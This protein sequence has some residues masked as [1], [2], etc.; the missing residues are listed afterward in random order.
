MRTPFITFLAFLHLFQNLIF[1]K[2]NLRIV[3]FSASS[4]TQGQRANYILKY[5]FDFYDFYY[6]LNH[7]ILIEFGDEHSANY[8]TDVTCV[9]GIDGHMDGVSLATRIKDNRLFIR[10]PHYFGY[11]HYS[12]VR[13]YMNNLG[14]TDK[15]KLT[16]VISDLLNPSV[17]FASSYW[18]RFYN[19]CNNK[20]VHTNHSKISYEPDSHNIELMAKST[21]AFVPDGHYS[22]PVILTINQKLTRNIKIRAYSVQSGVEIIPNVFDFEAG[23]INLKKFRI[24]PQKKFLEMNK[25][26]SLLIKFELLSESKKPVRFPELALEVLNFDNA[27]QVE[28]FR[29]Q[30]KICFPV[31]EVY[32]SINHFSQGKLTFPINIRLSHPF[33]YNLTINDF[34]S[35]WLGDENIK[36][37]PKNLTIHKGEKEFGLRV[38]IQTYKYVEF[39]LDHNMRLYDSNTFRA[40]NMKN[41][42]EKQLKTTIQDSLVN[43]MKTTKNEIIDFDSWKDILTEIPLDEEFFLRYTLMESLPFYFFVNDKIKNFEV[44]HLQIDSRSLYTKGKFLNQTQSEVMTLK[45]FKGSKKKFFLFGLKRISITSEILVRGNEHHLLCVVFFKKHMRSS[46]NGSKRVIQLYKRFCRN[47]SGLSASGKGNVKFYLGRELGVA[48]CTSEYAGQQFVSALNL[49]LANLDSYFA[50]AFIRTQ[51]P[52]SR[53]LNYLFDFKKKEKTTGLYKTML[54]KSCM[55]KEELQAYLADSAK[56]EVISRAKLF[57]SMELFKKLY[58]NETRYFIQ[59]FKLPI[60]H[61]LIMSLK[62]KKCDS[63]RKKTFALYWNGP[64]NELLRFVQDKLKN[65]GMTETDIVNFDANVSF[66]KLRPVLRLGKVGA[67]LVAFKLFLKSEQFEMLLNFEIM[68]TLFIKNINEKTIQKIQI[69]KS[70][71]D[72]VFRQ[73]NYALDSKRLN[74]LEHFWRKLSDSPAMFES[75]SQSKTSFMNIKVSGLKDTH[76]YQFHAQICVM[77]QPIS[78][79]SCRTVKTQKREFVTH[80]TLKNIV[81]VSGATLYSLFFAGIVAVLLG[82]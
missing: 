14:A 59:P 75:D 50:V 57:E 68:I 80:S 27:S 49:D 66:S 21:C 40:L 26:V 70:K 29:T 82:A 73:I 46:F 47:G 2:A 67:K 23:E 38:C 5:E 55:Q 63:S 24:L 37:L 48:K 54:F 8:N 30:S 20:L 79:R 34:K 32:P 61:S 1:E 18:I 12:S 16:L 35:N 31:A 28:K 42:F 71:D 4:L 33:S 52:Q 77:F 56:T 53:I 9:I 36:I 11:A 81:F 39:R 58:K 64:R 62:E 19:A 45:K 72:P 74:K 78:Y 13:N 44:S 7:N 65:P 41:L 69:M 22:A 60:K 3:K 6:L 10:V 17:D 51:K 76:Y 25:S 15:I 43:I